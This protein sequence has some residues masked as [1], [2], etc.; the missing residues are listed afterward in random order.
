MEV[1]GAQ[2][3]DFIRRYR[4]ERRGLARRKNLQDKNSICTG[5]RMAFEPISD[6]HA[7]QEVA[8]SVV[9]ARQFSA[10]EF[11]SIIER[12]DLWREDLPGA[13]RETLQPVLWDG[14]PPPA[15]PGGMRFESYR[16]DGSIDWRLY[17][18]GNHIGVQC[19]AYTRWDEVSAKALQ[20]LTLALGPMAEGGPE[21]SAVTLH[22]IDVFK[23]AGEVADYDTGELLNTK[24]PFFPVDFKD[25]LAGPLWHLHQGWFTKA[26]FG[27]SLNRFHLDA[28]LVEPDHQVRLDHFLQDQH[29]VA[30]GLSEM[31]SD[32]G[33][34]L[35]SRF[36]GLHKRNKEMVFSVLASEVSKRI[37]LNV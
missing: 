29:D 28:V 22:C 13:Y 31:L 26:D 14:V 21:V 2:H 19:Y 18:Q 24:A 15:I 32:D 37:A 12:H 27:R 23:W 34:T 3:P 35:K 17:V 30:M 33:A 8:F 5:G 36:L 20:Y 6:R 1:R 9:L 7:I 4:G 11:N 25:R 10:E 16:R